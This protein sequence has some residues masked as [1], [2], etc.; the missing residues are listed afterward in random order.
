M[1]QDVTEGPAGF[2]A[3]GNEVRAGDRPRRTPLAWHSTDGTSWNRVALPADL[4]EEDR[5]ALDV[6]A[7]DIGYVISGVTLDGCDAEEGADIVVPRCPWRHVLTA[8]SPD[9][10]E[11]T[12]GG[13]ADGSFT[14]GV[15]VSLDEVLWVDDHFVAAGRNK[16]VGHDWTLDVWQSDD[17]I[18][19]TRTVVFDDVWPAYADVRL[20]EAGRNV[21]LSASVRECSEVAELADGERWVAD[22]GISVGRLWTSGDGGATWDRFDFEEVGMAGEEPAP[23]DCPWVTAA[24][25]LLPM[26]GDSLWWRRNQFIWTSPDGVTWEPATLPSGLPRDR[27]PTLEVIAAADD[28]SITV[29][30]FMIREGSIVAYARA[31]GETGGSSGEVDVFAGDGTYT[32]IDIAVVEE[33]SVFVEVWTADRLGAVDWT[34]W[35]RY[36]SEIQDV[37]IPGEERDRRTPEIWA[38][39][40]VWL[41]YGVDDDAQPAQPLILWSRTAAV[42]QIPDECEPGPQADCRYSSLDGDD[43]SGRDLRG[44]DLRHA[45]LERVDLSGADLTGAQLDDADLAGV[46]LTDAVLDDASIRRVRIG[47]SGRRQSTFTGARAR[48]ADLRGVVFEWSERAGLVDAEGADLT[49]ADLTGA[50]IPLSS[51]LVFTDAVLGDTTFQRILDL[52]ELQRILDLEEPDEGPL[53][54]LPG[55]TGDH[56]RFEG[57]FRG[58]DF[59]GSHL[60]NT[61][62][63]GV[64]DG[65]DFSG[66]D[67]TGSSFVGYFRGADFRGSDLTG[68]RFELSLEEALFAG[69]TIEDVSWVS[70][71]TLCPDGTQIRQ[72]DWINTPPFESCE[73]HFIDR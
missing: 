63:S 47:P 11:W 58:A 32:A 14:Q 46:D 28:G 37:A 43:L 4:G 59:S 18:G 25:G 66:S 52:E 30:E 53:I 34:D 24:T 27:I 55:L 29:I 51:G 12:V 50:T 54:M 17:G 71:L 57:D 72:S 40:E 60:T 19:W 67:L 21:V 62:F 10:L 13:A 23:A 9:G 36:A 49:G 69:A 48:G 6:A 8:F 64:F 45:T 22:G 15:S 38:G 7:G 31:W 73:G 2:I 16:R 68:S 20:Q 39:E 56:L 42:A 26:P 70:K 3:V 44:I 61:R 35:S 41:A 65:A 5:F 1:V 33:G